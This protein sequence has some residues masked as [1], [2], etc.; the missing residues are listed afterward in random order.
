MRIEVRLEGVAGDGPLRYACIVEDL[1]VRREVW[2]R[3]AGRLEASE[4]LE[5]SLREYRSLLLD[6]S[7]DLSVRSRRWSSLTRQEMQIAGLILSGLSSKQSADR[8]SISGSTAKKHTNAIFRKLGVRSRAEFF[9]LKDGPV[10]DGPEGRGEP[11]G[12][13][14]RGAPP[15]PRQ[16]AMAGSRRFSIT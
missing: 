7:P 9:G 2:T 8:A 10:S 14:P 11:R 13:R 12:A 4:R 15:G 1:I 6:F 3:E 5:R 16:A